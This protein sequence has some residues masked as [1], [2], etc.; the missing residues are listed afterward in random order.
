MKIVRVKTPT[1]MIVA[2]LRKS[3]STRVRRWLLVA[4]GVVGLLSAG[5]VAFT[6]PTDE[7]TFAQEYFVCTALPKAEL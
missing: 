5:L 3:V 1:H 6:G 2:E 7:H 4:S